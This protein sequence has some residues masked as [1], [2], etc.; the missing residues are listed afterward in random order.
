MIKSVTVVNYLGES[1][2][3]E[4]TKPDVSGFVIKYITGLGPVKAEINNTEISTGDG[5]I[6]NSARLNSRNIVLGLSFLPNPTIEDT[7][8]KSY[9]YFPIK[10]AVKLLFET[11]NRICEC[12]GYVESNEP[13]IFDS[14][15]STRISVIC[16][17]PNLYSAGEE[18]LRVTVFSGIEALFE[19]PFSNESQVE[20]LLEF[21]EIQNNTERT[22]VY[23]GDLEIGLTI[24]IY[25][26]GEA[27][28]ITIYNSG[29]REMMRI[30]TDKLKKLTGSGIIASDQLIITTVRNNKSV[31]LLRDGVYTNVL[32]ILE[33][34]ADW[35]QLA[36]G[37]NVF[38]YVAETGMTNLQFRIENQTVYEGI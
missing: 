20:D 27:S 6:Y 34:D 9:K 5:A 33:R 16:S 24:H 28:N 10:K 1:I 21:G 14:Q 3:I 25:A 15:E 38:V 17:D 30:N 37:D 31:T 36:K 8:Q 4:L 19:F 29:T 18:G 7:R 11:D 12:V 13:N 32:N 2:K 35:F 22:I 26:I 23:D